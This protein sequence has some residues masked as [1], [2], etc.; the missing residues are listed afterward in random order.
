MI[1]NTGQIEGIN[2]NEKLEHELLIVKICPR[3][4]FPVVTTEETLS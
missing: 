3:K 1:F 2:P 4:T